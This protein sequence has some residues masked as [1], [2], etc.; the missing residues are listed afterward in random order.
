LRD[1]L[2]AW[3]TRMMLRV[4][5]WLSLRQAQAIG[6]LFGRLAWWS[7]GRAAKVTQINIAVCY[8]KLDADAQRQLARQSLLH[9]GQLS[10]EMGIVWHWSAKAWRPL[11]RKVSGAQRIAD[12][13]HDKRGVLVLAPHFGNWEILNLFLG[14]R[15]GLTAMYEPPNVAHLDAVIRAARMRAGSILVPTTSS[16][17][18]ELY[19]TL[20]R[21]KLVGLLPDQVPPLKSG[22]HAPFFGR[23]ALTGILAHKIIRATNPLVLLGH[24]R[25]LPD[26]AGF[27]LHFDVLPAVAAA[28]DPETFAIA[29]NRATEELVALDPAQY[30]WEYKRFRRGPEDLDKLY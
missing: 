27:N 22:V 16:G 29:L 11:I 28:E 1:R 6:R 5:S 4:L 8:P 21:G 19:R 18:R 12:A 26:A 17:I 15:F 14:E 20:R 24:A 10:A 7:G 2:I 30:Q 9:T 13:L 23:P 25:R 3:L